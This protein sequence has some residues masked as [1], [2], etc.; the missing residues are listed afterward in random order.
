[1]PND[2]REKLIALYASEETEKLNDAPD[3]FKSAFGPNYEKIQDTDEYKWLNQTILEQKEK[4]EKQKK[5]YKEK[6]GEELGD[7]AVQGI[8]CLRF[9]LIN[10]IFNKDDETRYKK[11]MDILRDLMIAMYGSGW[12]KEVGAHFAF[13]YPKI[14]DWYL[15]FFSYANDDPSIQELNIDLS[16]EFWGTNTKL[17]ELIVQILRR[18]NIQK[19]FYDKR[20]IKT[21]DRLTDIFK[22]C[23]K[24]FFFIQLISKD[25]LA[26]DDKNWSLMEYCEFKKINDQLRTKYPHYA[27]ILEARFLFA[28]PGKDVA[29]VKPG[30]VMPDEY[31][32]WYGHVAKEVHHTLLPNEKA[33]FEAAVKEIANRVMTS[34]QTKW[35]AADLNE[36]PRITDEPLGQ[37]TKL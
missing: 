32:D 36:T 10:A 15:F 8:E 16:T 30:G 37:L 18:N 1:V 34:L 27:N 2:V 17:A 29:E 13:L 28:V 12:P 20:D 6:H 7:P 22:A 21:G 3:K 31:E 11:K 9:L 35:I 19:C 33:R 14:R 5:R 4:L 23:A 26:F 25:S 24:S